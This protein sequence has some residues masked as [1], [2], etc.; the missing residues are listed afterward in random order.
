MTERAISRSLRG[1]ASEGEGAIQGHEALGGLLKFH[2][3]QA[4]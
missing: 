2:Y 1:Q 3:R 4:A